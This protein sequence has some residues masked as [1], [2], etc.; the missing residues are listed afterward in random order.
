MNEQE[1]KFEK[2]IIVCKSSMM[3]RPVAKQL[4]NH[5]VQVDS[6]DDPDKLNGYWEGRKD[7][8]S[9]VLLLLTG[10]EDASWA[11]IQ[12]KSRLHSDMNTL[13]VRTKNN[14]LDSRSR[15]LRSLGADHVF[16]NGEDLWKV[17]QRVLASKFGSTG[18]NF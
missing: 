8:K 17:I 3:V 14:K 5:G 13:L 7:D 2:A 4:E 1:I 15:R 11:T 9:I 16:E 6:Y 10:L 12:L 18:K